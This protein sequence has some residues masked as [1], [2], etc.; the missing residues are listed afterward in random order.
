MSDTGTRGRIECDPG[1]RASEG[2]KFLQ[3]GLW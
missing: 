2:L 1:P 3:L